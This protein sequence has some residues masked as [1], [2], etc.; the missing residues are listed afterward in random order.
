MT[1]PNED[2]Q[3]YQ[4]E[5]I[6]DDW[7]EDDD[8]EGYEDSRIADAVQEHK[9]QLGLELGL[10]QEKL[11]RQLTSS[12]IETALKGAAAQH[13]RG[14]QPDVNVVYSEAG[15]ALP[16]TVLEM[17]DNERTQFMRERFR[18]KQTAE[19]PEADD[20]EYDL[21]VDADR[22]AY[23]KARMRGVEFEDAE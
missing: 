16:K 9:A 22:V 8:N 18:D 4:Y 23:M 2:D 15:S 17:T 6:E 20:R 12:E 13:T 1:D 3:L 14:Q 10:Y 19:Q 21:S 7:E 11:G 5:D